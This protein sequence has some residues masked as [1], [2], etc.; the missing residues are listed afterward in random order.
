MRLH[1]DDYLL[2]LL[3]LLPAMAYLA[4][5]SSLIVAFEIED[6]CCTTFAYTPNGRIRLVHVDCCSNAANTIVIAA[7]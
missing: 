1:Y 7:P 2:L 5:R 3:I 4:A 6:V